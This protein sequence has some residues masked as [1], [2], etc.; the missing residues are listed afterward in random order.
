MMMKYFAFV[1]AFAVLAGCD[2]FE[3]PQQFNYPPETNILSCP[4]EDLA[5]GDSLTIRWEGSDKDGEVAGYEWA[6]DR[7][8]WAE[9]EA[10]SI[11]LRDLTPGEHMIS[12]RAIDDKGDNDPTPAECIFDVAAGGTYVERCVLVELF[13]T[14]WCRNCPNSE[15]ALNELE[16][17]IGKSNLCIVAYHDT[18]ERDG[19]AT[20]ETAE[21]IDWYWDSTGFPGDRDVWPTVIID[22]LHVVQGAQ[23]VEVA[24]SEYEFEIN[25]RLTELSRL[26]L[27]LTGSLASQGG[28]VKVKLRL[29]H[30]FIFNELKLHLLIIE[31]SVSYHGWFSDSFD[32]VVRDILD[33]LPLD[34]TAVGDSLV[35]EQTVIFDESWDFPNL[36][37]IAFVQDTSTKEVIQ[38]A[39]LKK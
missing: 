3:E 17:Q 22:G 32:F 11:I 14:T 38:A 2:W 12:V 30:E 8:G 19:L 6:L 29:Q 25:S 26:S 36:D 1:F 18:P 31:D 35:F 21:R 23:S 28:S 39:R 13:T 34:L 7:G 5:P 4:S 16:K 10:E 20:S 27:A 24:K 33:A 37:V 9:T 15:E